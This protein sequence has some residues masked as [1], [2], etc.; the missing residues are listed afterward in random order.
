MIWNLHQERLRQ[1]FR[2]REKQM[3]GKN[4]YISEKPKIWELATW[5]NS[6]NA[7]VG[8]ITEEKQLLPYPLMWPGPSGW[9]TVAR[10]KAL[11]IEFLI[12][13]G[14]TYDW[15]TTNP[16]QQVAVLTFDLPTAHCSTTPNYKTR[17]YNISAQLH[18]WSP[19]ATGRCFGQNFP[20]WE[21]CNAQTHLEGESCW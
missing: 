21:Y 1:P 12:Y 19:A 13:R 16:S 17:Q 11:P 3:L 8:S 20:D 10:E 18:S 4:K 14:N 2:G 9:S 5:P 6:S 15:L 7:Q